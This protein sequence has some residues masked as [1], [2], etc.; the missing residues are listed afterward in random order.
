MDNILGIIGGGQLGKMLLQVCQQWAVKTYVLDP[1]QEPPCQHYCHRC[2]VGSLLDYQTVLDFGRQCQLVTYE[3]EHINIGALKQLEKEG[4]KIYPKPDTLELI[5]NKN[6]QKQFF[7]EHQ[8]PTSRFQ[9]VD[10][11]T[12]AL[13]E[14][15]VSYPCVWKKTTLGY[16]GF[17][18]KVCQLA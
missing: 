18:V 2:F 10:D 6:R 3:I 11:F 4:V 5:Q 12:V 9:C 14:G 7:V 1:S 8:F 13:Q 17:G 16:D 15:L